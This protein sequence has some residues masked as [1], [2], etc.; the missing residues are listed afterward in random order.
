[1]NRSRRDFL[2]ATA[3]SAAA[4]LS[5]GAL[6]QGPKQPGRR[7]KTEL[8][9]V[10]VAARQPLE[11]GPWRY[12]DGS[13]ASDTVLMFRGNP[14]H[15]FY[16]TGP[17]PKQPRLRWKYRMA[18]FETQLRGQTI[19]WSGTG[20][21]G[22]AAK[23]GNYVF[24]GSVGRQVYAFE[25]MTG[26]VAWT[27][28]G[29]RMFKSSLCIYDNK[30]YIG[31]V[32]D[33][34][35]CIDAAT[36]QLVWTLNTYRDLDS[37]PC[38]VGGRLYIAGENGHARCID[39]RTGKEVWKTFLGGVGPGTLGGSN[40]SE[41]SPAIADGELYS[42]T[43]D[44]DLF[45]LNVRDGSIKWKTRTHGDTD[46][47]PVV[48]GEFVYAAAEEDA[49]NLY[50]FARENGREIWRYTDNTA[51]YWS[52]PAVAGDRIWIGG[53]DRKMH[54]VEAK[55]G[56]GIWQFETGAAVWSSPAVVDD[57]VIFGSRDGHLYIVDA[58]SGKKLWSFRTDG[59]IISS[60]CVVDGH[61][62]IGT[63]TGWF[64]C[65]GP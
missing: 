1:M 34:L 46:A 43:Y 3:F 45:C 2:R 9:P 51:G 6:A 54:C 47:S 15:T 10:A 16:G 62:W 33:H 36:G 26:K 13:F 20:W 37:S 4:A 57:R 21:T 30:I 18:D 7:D 44:G 12:G 29:G 19:T 23:L 35:R 63:A 27:F 50:C 64:Y 8:E 48:S 40:G 25:A 58:K 24:V 41:T 60:P 32:D 53:A 14:A 28:E 11:L 61:I 59:R 17:V 5:P 65:F 52:T 38:V 42:A 55:T 22:T 39:A 31:N 56:R 49:P